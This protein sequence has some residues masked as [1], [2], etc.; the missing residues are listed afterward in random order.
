MPGQR[1]KPKRDVPYGGEMLGA[2]APPHQE[3]LFSRQPPGKSLSILFLFIAGL[4]D[5]GLCAAHAAQVICNEGVATVV[6]SSEL[7]HGRGGGAGVAIVNGNFSNDLEGW[8]VSESGGQIIAGTV[9]ATSGRAVLSEGDSFLV[10]LWQTFFLPEFASKLTFSL[11]LNPGFDRADEFIPDAFEVSLLDEDSKPVLGSWDSVAT[12]SFNIQEDGTIHRS[13]RVT[14]EGVGV[15]F[16]VSS[17][18]AGTE[19]TLLFDFIGADSDTLGAVSVD[20]VTLTRA[21]FVR[22]E[23][24]SDKRIDISDPVFTLSF[25][26]LGGVEPRC[27]DALDSDN[28]GILNI[29]DPIYTLNFLFLG[30]PSIPPPYPDCGPDFGPEDLLECAD[31]PCSA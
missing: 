28:D 16:D 20:D 10:T 17:V 5:S 26:F 3:G 6:R 25:L 23:A 12:S 13:E 8:T 1:G 2:V 22:G 21:G 29:T 19:L 27:F 24:N 7:G 9:H 14:L 18:P 30:G 4:L 15:I 31:S 11:S